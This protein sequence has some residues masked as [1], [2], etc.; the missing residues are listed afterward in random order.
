VRVN[1][2]ASVDGSVQGVDGT[3]ESLSNRADRAILGAIRAESDAVLVGAATIRTEGYLLPRTARLAIVTAS[4]D[5]SGARV[6]DEHDPTKIL[7][8]APESAR[9]RV[10]ATF[11]APHTFVGVTADAVGRIDLPAALD[12]LRLH[13]AESV[14]CEGGP[15]LIDQLMDAGLVGELCISTSPTW[16]GGGTSLLASG[17]RRATPLRLASLLTDDTGGIYARW[18]ISA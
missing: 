17:D 2:I 13:G 18:I 10:H 11:G 9:E 4:G 5:L 7:I 16:I 15:H 3:S 14:V 6:G 12:A 8:L 1:I